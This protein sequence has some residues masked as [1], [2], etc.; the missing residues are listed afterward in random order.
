M[1]CLEELLVHAKPVV[2]EDGKVGGEIDD[3]LGVLV[4]WEVRVDNEC[5]YTT[6]LDSIQSLDLFVVNKS[7]AEF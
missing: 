7:V 6:L 2:H 3:T 1:L 5:L 4:G